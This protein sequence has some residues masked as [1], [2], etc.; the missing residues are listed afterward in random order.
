MVSNDYVVRFRNR[1]YQLLPPALAGLRGGAVVIEE[2]LDGTMAMRFGTRYLKYTGAA[3]G[4]R[5]GGPAPRPPEFSALTA[6]ASGGEEGP[7]PKKR[8]RAGP[9]GMQPSGGRSGRTPALPYPPAG[10]AEDSA[11]RPYRPAQNH[12][13]RKPFKR[14]K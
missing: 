12:P 7:A 13:W 14:K 1:F 10:A 4:V 2:R 5:P 11:K 6:D 8:K 3:A 9:T